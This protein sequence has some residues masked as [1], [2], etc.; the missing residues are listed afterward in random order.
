MAIKNN[1]FTVVISES[2]TTIQGFAFFLLHGH[3][4]NSAHLLCRFKAHIAPCNPRA[5][6]AA[7]GVDSKIN[8]AQIFRIPQ[9]HRQGAAEGQQILSEVVE[10]QLLHVCNGYN[11]VLLSGKPQS[12]L[13]Q[14]LIPVK[15]FLTLKHWPEALQTKVIKNMEET[16]LDL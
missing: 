2:I 3:P 7:C 6:E 9:C 8:E 10:I 11:S 4:N 13:G 16:V 12:N 1:L 15:S 14:F 5:R